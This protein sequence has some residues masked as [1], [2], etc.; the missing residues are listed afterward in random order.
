MFEALDM[1]VTYLKR[2]AFGNISL[3][4][5]LALGEYRTLTIEEIESWKNRK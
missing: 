4:S 3:D 2:V 5:S 1:K